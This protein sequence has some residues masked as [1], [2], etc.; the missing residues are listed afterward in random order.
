MARVLIVDDEKSIR[1]TL[2]E[3]LKADGHHVWTAADGREARVQLETLR[4]DVVVCDV[5]L[6]DA[7]G[8]DILHEAR[9]FHPHAQVVL[10]TGEPTIETAAEAVRGAAFDY[11]AKPVTRDAV[12]R[13]VAAA[14]ESA[15]IQG[16]TARLEEQSRRYREE[17]EERV[18]RQTEEIARSEAAHRTLAENLPGLV[19]RMEL[20]PVKEVR[21]F[22][23]M[24]PVMTGYTVEELPSGELSPLEALI[25]DEDRPGVANAIR[26]A[27]EARHSFEL[28]YRVACKSGEIRH[29]LSRGRPVHAAGGR[30]VHVD[31]VILD[32]TPRRNAEEHERQLVHRQTLVNQLSVLLGQ[33]FEIDEIYRSIYEH[34]RKLFTVDA[35]IVSHY[36]ST[37]QSIRAGY[38]VTDGVVRDASRL[39]P[40][41][42][43]PEGHG[44]QSH[45]IRT[46]EALHLPDFSVGVER[47]RTLHAIREDGEPG[48]GEREEIQRE[49]TT[50]SAILVPMKIRGDVVGV[51]QVQSKRLG[52]Y[53][54]D[55]VD[56]LSALANVAAVA[57]Q[58]AQLTRALRASLEGVIRTLGATTEMRD[59]YTAGHQLRVTRL[60][61]AIA[62]QMGLPPDR[63]DAV[64]TAATIHDIGKIAIPAE[65][66]SKPGRLTGAERALLETHPQVAHGILAEVEFPWPIADI[67]LQHHERL[68][69]SGYPRGLRGGEILLEARIIGV[70]DVVEAMASHRPYREALGRT[71]ALE[72][73]RS[74]R[75]TAFDPGAVDACIALFEAGFEL[76]LTEEEQETA[77]A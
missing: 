7:S 48:S 43:E 72:E 34:V 5:V 63:I 21:F 6:L 1:A 45:V 70:A 37:A 27:I 24:L 69:G 64:R 12:R 49:Y 66:L 75:G 28:E 8:L 65:L 76:E 14:A 68:D 17:L 33:V 20:G 29:F 50:Q 53:S 77:I 30:P 58:N 57:L 61:C 10:I 41:P 13:I 74:Q 52:D 67:V 35:F 11:L 62:K 23:Q 60:A 47:T 32:V 18:R 31:G 2:S 19:Y 44:V 22:N 71:A 42:L 73:I 46:G 9:R 55:D 51:I 56:L 36:D 40:I 25:L 3:F 59:P 26:S 39:P 16:E 54:N 15:W 4:I 38:L